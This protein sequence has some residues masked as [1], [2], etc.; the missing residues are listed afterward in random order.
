MTTE[1]R[2]WSNVPIPPGE[3]LEEEIAALGMTQQELALRTGR[4]V[5][6]INEIVRG[7][8]AI[9]HDTAL[10]LEKVLGVPAHVWIN[11]EAEYQLTKA[12]LRDTDELKHQQDWL[13]TFPVRD[14]ERRGWIQ[15]ER[16]KEGKVRAL[17]SFFGV[18]SFDA[19]R[20][21]WA[22]RGQEVPVGFRVT[23]GSK[24]SQPALLTWLR[25]GEI[26]GHACSTS[27]FDRAR[28]VQALIEARSFTEDPP[29]EFLP[30]LRSLCAEAGVAIVL[31]QEIP[32][33]G[34]NGAARWLGPDKALIQLS[35]RYKTG[36]QLWFSFFHEAG[37]ILDRRIKSLF[38]DN[39]GP[40]DSPAEARANE[41]A[42][43][44]LCPKRE[45][46]AFIGHNQ[47]DVAAVTEFSRKIKLHPGIV[48]GRLQHERQIPLTSLNS[49][50]RKLVWA[51]EV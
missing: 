21:V 46:L 7:K 29:Q 25:K 45:W 3:I 26:D 4:P 32:K 27:S 15:T 48:V 9:T 50:K 16:T 2:T 30:K 6:V 39:G 23:P 12:R 38:V 20:T 8:K 43:D 37:H 44:L 49:L 35:L 11:L 42:A 47:F 40:A 10:E 24:V 34:A 13:A 33:S 28:F 31:T 1:L 5:Q 18:V 17:L 51:Q 22:D 41:F 14:M 19:L 36:D